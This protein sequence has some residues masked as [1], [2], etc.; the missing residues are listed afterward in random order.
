MSRDTLLVEESHDLPLVHFQIVI[1]SGSSE[2][3]VGHEGLTRLAARCLRRGTKSRDTRSIEETIDALGA[4]LGIET[5]PNYVRISGSC[6][7][8]S[9]EPT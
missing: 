2:D 6:I 9:L 5:N 3:P 1:L 8:R 4:E 7:K